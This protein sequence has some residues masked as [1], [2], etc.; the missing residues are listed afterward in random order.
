MTRNTI[1]LTLRAGPLVATVLPDLGGALGRFATQ[2]AGGMVDWL[3]P[4]PA[5]PQSPLDC[6]AFLAVPY[7]S[8]LQGDRLIFD[9]TTWPQR[10]AAW[11]F[12][13]A[14]HGFGWQRPWQ[15]VEA[16]DNRVVLAQHYAGD[17]WPSAYDVRQAIVLT[18]DR[19]TV[20][21]TLTNLGDRDMPAG[22]GFH[23][24]FPRTDGAPAL[25]AQVQARHVTDGSGWPVRAL[26]D[27]P[28]VTALG[29][30]GPILNG[31]NSVYSGWNGQA[32]LTWPHGQV[33]MEVSG[34][35]AEFLCVYTPE[36][37]DFACVEPVSHT[38]DAPNRPVADV[39]P[40]G[41]RRL[42]PGER[43]ATEL[44]LRPSLF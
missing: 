27:D 11:G 25:M 15:I 22:V 39:G 24:Y 28:F 31:Q 3:R 43:L 14:L 9:G 10:P 13:H 42:K 7:F 2:T 17:D 36:G 40:T 20:E 26:A 41:H 33:E 35:A 44:R 6:A 38:I 23:P 1:P 30:G 5:A 8:R 29:A 12:G 34:P 4:A 16:L 18:D 19:L 32:R 37:Q 21:V